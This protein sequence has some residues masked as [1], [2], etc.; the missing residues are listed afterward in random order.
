MLIS[1]KLLMTDMTCD[2]V[3]KVYRGRIEM[4]FV[5]FAHHTTRTVSWCN[6]A[7]YSQKWCSLLK[8]LHLDSIRH[9]IPNPTLIHTHL[10]LPHQFNLGPL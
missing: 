5:N 3:S 7:E 6:N 9:Y 2:Q 4:S 8:S 10:S 1:L